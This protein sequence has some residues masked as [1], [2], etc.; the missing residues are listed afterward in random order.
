V[1]TT[2][3]FNYSKKES[4]LSAFTSDELKSMINK[5]KNV[6]IYHGSLEKFVNEFE[7]NNIGVSL[8]KYCL[9]LSL[10][11]LLCEIMLLRL[12]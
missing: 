7:E 4:D 2:L 11:F 9:V 1:V 3:A 8:W 5:K 6:H 12:Y 10:I